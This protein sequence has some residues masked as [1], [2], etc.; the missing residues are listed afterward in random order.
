MEPR[1]VLTARARGEPAF[2]PRPLPLIGPAG[3][4]RDT[5]AARRG[6]ASRELEWGA[7]GSGPAE[8]CVRHR[9]VVRGF[10]RWPWSQDTGSAAQEGL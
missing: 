3:L 9:G 10:G 5:G 8:S 1:A 6:P 2:S 7:G 4:P